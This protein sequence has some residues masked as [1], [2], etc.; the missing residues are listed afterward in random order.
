[1]EDKNKHVPKGNKVH[2]IRNIKMLKFSMIFP[3]NLL[4]IAYMD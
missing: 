3:M 4:Y 2:D 1:M